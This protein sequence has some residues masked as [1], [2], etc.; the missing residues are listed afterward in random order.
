[1]LREAHSS[2]AAQKIPERRL[3]QLGAIG[4]ECCV[5]NGPDRMEK[6]EQE[7][8]LSVPLGAELNRAQADDKRK[9]AV[10]SGAS[11]REQV[12]KAKWHDGMG[13]DEIDKLT[14]PQLEGIAFVHFHLSCTN[15]LGT[16]LKEAKK[17]VFLKAL[18]DRRSALGS[19]AAGGG[20]GSRAEAPQ[21][22][23]KPD[24]F[25]ELGAGNDETFGNAEPTRRMPSRGAS[26]KKARA[27]IDYGI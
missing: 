4:G 1:M 14:V 22:E 19:G 9:K 16:G 27:S 7:L 24:V 8:Q 25:S 23:Q 15:P 13:L 3:D 6:L 20:G 21:G 11:H 18:A 26:R 5:A 17:A 12:Q 2:I 10:I